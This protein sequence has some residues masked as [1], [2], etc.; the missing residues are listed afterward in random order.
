MKTHCKATGLGAL[1]LALALSWAVRAQDVGSKAPPIEPIDWLNSKYSSMDW[2]KIRGRLILVDRWATWCGPCVRSIPHLNELQEKYGKKGLAVVGVTDEPTSKI[3]TFMSSHTMDYL[4]ATG[5]KDVYRNSAIPHA[6]LISP[7]GEVLWRGHPASLEE[8]Q[9]EENLAGATV[10]PHFELPEA[11]GK[12]QR[13]LEAGLFARGLGELERYLKRPDDETT[14][15]QARKAIEQINGYGKQQLSEVAELAKEGEYAVAFEMLTEVES[16]FKGTE[17]GDSAR[18]RLREWKSD[19]TVRAELEADA[20]IQK[21]REL[22]KEK[23]YR[24]AHALLLRLTKSRKYDETKA[25]SRAK[26]ELEDLA[27]H[28]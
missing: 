13:Y 3:E 9:I 18:E 7:G 8:S 19:R 27:K 5:V 12:A 16:M 10:Y 11:L 25:V 20:I 2:K 26:K 15:E 28:I 23:N 17:I 6:W 14:A 1:L 21:A 24:A 4:V 22:K